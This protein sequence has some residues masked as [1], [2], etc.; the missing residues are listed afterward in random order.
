MKN[1][2]L[3]YERANVELLRRREPAIHPAELT[4]AHARARRLQA[5]E[6]HRLVVRPLGRMFGAVFERLRRYR[7][8]RETIRALAGL[9]DATL[10][11]IGLHRS[12]ITR[13][14][15]EM[16]AGEARGHGRAGVRA[17]VVAQRGDAANDARLE[18]EPRRLAS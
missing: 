16:A 6:L 5:A 15:V 8:E 17:G 11:D 12:E 2:D 7:S 9:S 3:L 1:Q 18:P 4:W 10:K 13:A 14:A